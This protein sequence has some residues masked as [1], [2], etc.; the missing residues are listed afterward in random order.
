MPQL[1]RT[2]RAAAC[3]LEWITLGGGTPASPGG[4]P[5]AKASVTQGLGAG[6]RPRRNQ[7]AGQTG[8]HGAS[9]I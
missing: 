3:G 8:P 1:T 5:A 6:P 2:E 4:E 7:A 9:R